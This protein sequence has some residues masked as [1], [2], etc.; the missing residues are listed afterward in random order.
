MAC[1]RCGGDTFGNQKICSKCLMDWSAMRKVIWD[2]HSKK[3]G[4]ISKEN[5]AFRQK[6]TKRL[7]K[8]WRKDKNKFQEIINEGEK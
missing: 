1:I 4:K 2:Y 5:L 3:H 7:E 6:D 8:I